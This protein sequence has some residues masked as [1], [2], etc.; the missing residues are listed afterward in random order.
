M[1]ESWSIDKLRWY[2]DKL[3]AEFDVLYNDHKNPLIYRRIGCRIIY[4][5]NLIKQKE[6][7]NFDGSREGIITI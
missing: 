5:I 4:I 7:D 1:F 6:G 3:Q 2:K